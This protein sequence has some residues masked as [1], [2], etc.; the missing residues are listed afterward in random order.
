MSKLDYLRRQLADLPVNE[1]AEIFIDLST[2]LQ[3]SD[4]L[5]GEDTTEKV[6]KFSDYKEGAIERLYNPNKI[7]GVPTGYDNLDSIMH[8][9]DGGDLIV[10][11]ADSAIG[12]SSFGQN[13]IHKVADRGIPVFYISL[14]MTNDESEKRF[15]EMD[16]DYHPCAD[17]Q[18][19]IDRIM[20]MPLYAFPHE[21]KITIKAIDES[22]Q[23]AIDKYGVKVVMIDHLH[24]FN[25]GTGNDSSEIG[26]IIRAIKL[27]ARKY[28]VP[29]LTVS[30]VTKP[31]GKSRPTMHDLRDSSFIYQDADI[32]IM[33]D[34]DKFAEDPAERKILK[35]WVEKNRPRNDIGEGQLRIT[36]GFNMTEMD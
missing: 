20:A 31:K 36:K 11:G 9:M 22:I 15:I 1:K 23:E 27:M 35:F 32:V 17:R 13:I 24:Y 6:V 25:R 5:I 34:R 7:Y 8:G 12:K 33:L 26:L 4:E 16:V 2:E 30:H 19:N 3:D 10:I 18:E 14:E 21:Q 29:I 28:N